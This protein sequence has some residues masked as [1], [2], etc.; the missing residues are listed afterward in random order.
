MEDIQVDFMLWDIL[1]RAVT[2]FNIMLVRK[3]TAGK[4][5]CSPMFKG[6]DILACLVDFSVILDNS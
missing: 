4:R 5:M 2:E 3:D 6:S 1:N